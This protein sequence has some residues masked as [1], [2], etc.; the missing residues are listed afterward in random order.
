MNFD[1][2]SGRWLA[3]ERIDQKLSCFFVLFFRTCVLPHLRTSEEKFR[4]VVFMTQKLYAFVGNEACAET[5]D[6]VFSW[7]VYL[8]GDVYLQVLKDAIQSMFNTAKLV[9]L[10]KANIRASS[11]AKNAA[12]A[13]KIKINEGE[14]S[15]STHCL[16]PFSLG[17]FICVVFPRKPKWEGGN[18]LFLI[19]HL[20]LTEFTLTQFESTQLCFSDLI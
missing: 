19:L 17:S 5:S 11:S 1:I 10:K 13:G 8:G 18:S 9:L 15:C 6:S 7:E 20:I 2:E 12:S 4:M 3:L 16:F 14:G